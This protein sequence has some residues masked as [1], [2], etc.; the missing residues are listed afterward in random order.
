MDKTKLVIKH[1]VM[2]LL[3]TFLIPISY[4]YIEIQYSEDN[5][6]NWRNI[7]AIDETQKEGYQINLQ[8]ATTYYFRGKNQTTG[9][10]YHIS[11]ITG[12]VGE[13]DIYYTY[14]T[15][16][17]VF[18]F[19]LWIG[20]HAEDYVFL[21]TAGMLC[22]I[23]ALHVFNESLPNI[24]NDFIKNSISILFAGIGFFYVIQPSIKL[25]EEWS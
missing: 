15:I 20:Y 14:I 10:W 13:T 7:T 9:V 16:L 24:T 8:P 5:A 21:I 12:G 1:I 3:I 19:L 25:I 17:I 22:C 2:V 6:T 4:A 18:F 11:Q 23:I